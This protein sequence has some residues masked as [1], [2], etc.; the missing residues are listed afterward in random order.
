MLQRA[1]DGVEDVA[2]LGQKGLG[3]ARRLGGDEFQHRGQV[4]GQFA[5]GQEEAGGLEG[6]AE[7]D[8][9]RAAFARIAVDVLK[10]MQRRGAAAVEQ[11][12][13]V[14]LTLQRFG[15][16][17]GLHQRIDFAAARRRQRA[18]CVHQFAHLGQVTAQ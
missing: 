4:V 15:V 17:D 6:L 18:F 1:E 10:E 7:V 12:D 2:H 8:H 16:G 11:L 14:G 5:F 9:R 13:V 3:L